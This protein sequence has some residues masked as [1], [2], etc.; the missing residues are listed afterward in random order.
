MKGIKWMLLGIAFMLIGI[1]M[2]IASAPDRQGLGIAGIVIGSVGFSSCFTAFSA[3]TITIKNRP[4][5]KRGRL[6]FYFGF[7]SSFRAPFKK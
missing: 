2:A 5:N 7:T 6:L 4:R 3:N 1:V